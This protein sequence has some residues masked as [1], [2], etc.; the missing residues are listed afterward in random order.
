MGIRLILYLLIL[1][2]G[3]VVGFKD[4]ANEKLSSK[5]SI[6]QTVCLL[7]LLFIMGIRIGLDDKV[8]ASFLKLGY[9]AL[10]ISIFSIV[11]SVIL[12]KAVK[13]YVMRNNDREEN[14]DDN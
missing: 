8:I 10:I 2:I 6:L 5:L 4:L 11:F 1:V 14:P 13:G 9:Q 3:G 7:G 12:V